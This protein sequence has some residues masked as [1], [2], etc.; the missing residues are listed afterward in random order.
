MRVIC[1]ECGGEASLVT[2]EEVYPHRPDLYKLNFWKCKCGAYVGCHKRRKGRNDIPLGSPAGEEVRKL[3]NK[4]H[5]RFDPMWKLGIL[6]RSDAYS[7]FAALMGIEK[8]KCHVGMFT[9]EQCEKAL[10]VLEDACTINGG[11][12]KNARFRFER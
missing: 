12:G 6:P 9:K 10:E 4:V 11:K 5:S 2:G 3:R 7:W 8:E 1:N